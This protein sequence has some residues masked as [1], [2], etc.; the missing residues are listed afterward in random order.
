MQATTDTQA[1]ATLDA[2]DTTDDADAADDS[3]DALSKDRVFELLKNRRRREVLH[4]LYEHDGTA[5]VSTLSEWIAGRENDVPMEEVTTTQR[6]RVYVG[7]YQTHLP[8]MADAGVV[9]YEQGE[10]GLE[11]GP[12][13]ERLY[14][15]VGDGNDDRWYQ[16]YAVLSLGGS[17][18][19]A[20]SQLGPVTAERMTLITT[21]IVGVFLVA[22]FVHAYSQLRPDAAV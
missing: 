7:L 14:Q 18:L 9:D 20:L 19:F 4:Y 5:S 2:P 6:K 12:N 22:A 17:G 21:A 15:Y 16:R 3:S 10:S 11:L 8:K 1:D 13:A